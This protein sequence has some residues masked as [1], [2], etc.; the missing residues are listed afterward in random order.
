MK[1]QQKEEAK[2]RKLKAKIDQANEIIFRGLLQT[3]PQVEAAVE[4]LKREEKLNLLKAQLKFRK[5]LLELKAGDPNLYSFYNTQT[6]HG[7]QHRRPDVVVLDKTKKKCHLID[8]AVV[9]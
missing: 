5:N 8:I 2:Q 4:G 1:Y 9:I 7:I 6:D 3:V